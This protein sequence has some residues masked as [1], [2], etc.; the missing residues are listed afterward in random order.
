MF[1][2]L[3][4]TL[5]VLWIGSA[6]LAH[7]VSAQGNG[8]CR[9]RALP[10]DQSKRWNNHILVCVPE[11][12]HY[13]RTNY[14]FNLK[15]WKNLEWKLGANPDKARLMMQKMR[16]DEEPLIQWKGRIPYSTIEEWNY[17]VWVFGNDFSCPFLIETYTDSEGKTQ[18]R[19][20]Q[21]PCWHWEIRYVTRH[22]SN[23]VM[24][25]DAEFIRPSTEEWGPHKENYHDIIPNGYDL[26]PGEIEDIQIFSN[27]QRSTKLAP[28]VSI[29]NAWSKYSINT[30]LT[31]HENREWIQ[32]THDQPTHLSVN[33]KWI[34]R[35]TDRTTP[36]TLRIPTN[37]DGDELKSL[38]RLE[39]TDADGKYAD[40]RPY[41]V[42]LVD[43]S[44]EIIKEMARQ[45]REYT[46]NREVAKQ[47][48][49][50]GHSSDFDDVETFEIDAKKSKD[51]KKAFWQDTQIRVRMYESIFLNRDRRRAK[52]YFT[53]AGKALE[54]KKNYVIDFSKSG[55]DGFSFYRSRGLLSNESVLNNVPID[56]PPNT[57][58][59]IYIRMFQPGVPFYRQENSSWVGDNR[60]SEPLELQF[61]TTSVDQ[62]SA[63][64]KVNDFQGK[65]LLQKFKWL[66]GG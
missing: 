27:S 37:E 20:T 59:Y 24:E 54:G 44:S 28:E 6:L 51:G 7:G 19:T 52:D 39:S 43:V 1:L 65:T 23:E 32:C 12:D 48:A 38:L 50:E 30:K 42:K 35:F 9:G 60:F 17:Q 29:G 15:A 34:E 11:V 53:S 3:K 58:F 61:K 5:I 64:Q 14:P 36:N 45:S 62:R 40:G 22:C 41:K 47:D 8:V 56:L 31:S 25:F 13:I 46:A 63:I 21:P 4:R 55:T 10:S 49:G 16:Q 18:T 26:L 2:P 57:S 66:F 33:I